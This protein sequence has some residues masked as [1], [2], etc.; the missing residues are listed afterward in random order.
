LL[1]SSA[2]VVFGNGE[3]YLHQSTAID[4]GM[5]DPLRINGNAIDQATHAWFEGA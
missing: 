5:I 2:L 1:G 4:G 3:L